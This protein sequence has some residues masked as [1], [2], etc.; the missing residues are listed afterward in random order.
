MDAAN[1]VGKNYF[2]EVEKAPLVGHAIEGMF[3]GAGETIPSQLK[4]K[5]DRVKGMKD[6]ELLRLLTEA[7][8][9]L[10]K[11]EDLAKGQDVTFSMHAMLAKLDR[12]TG[13][14]PPEVVHRFTDELA[15]SFRGIGV[16]FRRNE[17]SDQLQVV[18]PIYNSPAHKAGMKA[19]DII[20]TIISE[21]DPKTGQPYDQPKY[22]ET[23]GMTTE[24]A[25]KLIKGVPDTKIKLL[26]QR[27]GVEKPIE[28]TLVRKDI[29]V[30]SVLGHNRTAKDNWNYV[31]DQENRICYV[32]LTQFSK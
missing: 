23:K 17:A 20:T 25:V 9:I 14:V 7:R 29:E 5:L 30:E 31:I 24:D 13:Y 26:V 16:Q 18:T 8:Q 1:P 4:E 2:K 12:H 19:N 22:T 3:T 6:A 27:E 15:G 21:V 28:F 10:G 11:R 32:R